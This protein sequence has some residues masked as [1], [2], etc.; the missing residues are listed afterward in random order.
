MPECIAFVIV[1]HLDPLTGLYIALIICLVTSLL[2]GRPG[3]ISG[4]AGS[5]QLSVQ[6]L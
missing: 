4:A 5:Q 6:L 1:A 2:G 3:M